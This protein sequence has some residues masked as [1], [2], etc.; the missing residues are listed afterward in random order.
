MANNGPSRTSSWLGGFLG[1]VTEKIIQKVDE[2]SNSPVVKEVIK[3]TVEIGSNIVDITSASAKINS[4]MQVLLKNPDNIVKDL[5]FFQLS[6]LCSWLAT[7]AYDES[8]SETSIS[9][10][11]SIQLNAHYKQVVNILDKHMFWFVAHD[12]TRNIVYIVFRGTNVAGDIFIDLYADLAVHDMAPDFLVH[13]GIQVALHNEIKAIEE[14][15]EKYP[16]NEKT[17]FVLTG[18]S[19]GGGGA[20]LCHNYIRM[21]GKYKNN[22]MITITF[23]AP[24]VVAPKLGMWSETMQKVSKEVHCFV[25]NADVVP[26]LLGNEYMK[27]SP[28]VL[29]FLKQVISGG[30]PSEA[31]LLLQKFLENSDKPN[32]MDILGGYRPFGEY[33]LLF[34]KDQV[35]RAQTDQDKRNIV[36]FASLWNF[37]IVLEPR[38]MLDHHGMN[39]YADFIR[40]VV[41]DLKISSANN[42]NGSN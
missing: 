15:I 22:R 18:H 26:R 30:N 21:F 42:N 14:A 39:L 23:G 1:S 11:P 20:I 34:E 37:G 28:K 3:Q 32:F 36:A 24:L 41:K 25:H 8:T 29:E 40:D 5:P 38:K 16:V 4:E 27:L 31:R 7:R 19:L 9:Y 35:I 10:N 6:E 13:K 2:V 33:Y 17:Y 12:A